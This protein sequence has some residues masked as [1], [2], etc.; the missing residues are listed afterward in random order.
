MTNIHIK[1]SNYPIK[2]PFKII[3]N[4]NLMNKNIL[5]QDL[6]LEMNAFS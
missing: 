4:Y 5:S 1:A 3:M 2:N 6:R